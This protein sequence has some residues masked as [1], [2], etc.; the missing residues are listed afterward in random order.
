MFLLTF[1]YLCERSFIIKDLVSIILNP[2]HKLLD[3]EY[4]SDILCYFFMLERFLN[5]DIL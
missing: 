5:V 4:G 1:R 2:L 3:V